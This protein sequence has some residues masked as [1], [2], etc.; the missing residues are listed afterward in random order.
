MKNLKKYIIKSDL[1]IFTCLKQMNK[2]GL[3]TLIVSNKTNQY[4]GTISGG[5]IRKAITKGINL[6]K[7]IY[8]LFNDKSVYFLKNKIKYDVIKNKL[9]QGIDFVPIIDSKKKIIKVIDNSFF[10]KKKKLIN[11]T[12]RNISVVIMAG[13]KGTR[14]KP[15][16]KV[17]PKPL[18]PL[19]NK[20]LIE[21]VI[22]K[23]LDCGLTDFN[24]TT[25]Y[26]SQTLISFFK[27]LKPSYKVKFLIERKPL[28][29]IGGVKKIK[30]LKENVFV[31]N[32]DTIIKEN[33]NN[34]IDEHIK[35]KNQLTLIVANKQIRLP[36]GV[37]KKNRDGSIYQLT[38]KPHYNFMVNTGFYLINKNILKYIPTNSKYDTTDLIQ[39][40]IQNKL[41][42]GAYVI[43][44]KKWIDVGQ[45]N[46]YQNIL[47]A[48]E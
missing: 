10:L 3:K 44:E 40:L 47:K 48:I 18:M 4:I 34:I 6:K 14:L 39:N 46:E 21:H 45:L 37:C 27:E 19:G 17:L 22:N 9:M 41:K 28:G 43:N 15:L 29:T 23:F 31:T 7:K 5:D 24:L 13:G 35:K 8:H 1:S 38:E 25:N 30:S 16:T 26:K 20:T 32:C 2:Y 11:T 12:Q 33:Y 36:Y 42:L